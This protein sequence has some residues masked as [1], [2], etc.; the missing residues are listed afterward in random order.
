M[1][2]ATITPK[3][4]TQFI[5]NLCNEIN[6]QS[7]PI[8]IPVRPTKGAQVNECFGNVKA[9]VKR[10]NGF[11]QYGWGIWEWKNV[12]I[13]AEFHA[14]WKSPEGKLICVTPNPYKESKMLFLSDD[15]MEYDGVH[16]VDNIRKSLRIEPV[17]DE[18]IKIKKCA[19]TEFEKLTLGQF[20]NIKSFTPSTKLVELS[21]SEIVIR[22]EVD[23]LPD[24]PNRHSPC[25]CVAAECAIKIVA[26]KFII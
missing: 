10:D 5:L 14:V 8:Y 2:L 19:F 26:V 1:L 20:G 24:L 13:E 25:L 23:N 4:I 18:L 15:T 7:K 22:Q 3:G 16:R 12:L 11:L 9:K 6:P 17:V 21:K